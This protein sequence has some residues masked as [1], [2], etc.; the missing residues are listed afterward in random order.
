MPPSSMSPRKMMPLPL[1]I[2]LAPE[3]A[4]QLIATSPVSW[5]ILASLQIRMVMGA[6]KAMTV[7]NPAPRAKQPMR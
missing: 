3:R 7:K 6:I 2:K 1:V 5:S 4:P